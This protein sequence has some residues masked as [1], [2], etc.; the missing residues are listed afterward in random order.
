[1][2]RFVSSFRGFLAG[3]TLAREVGTG[4]LVSLIAGLQAPAL[5]AADSSAGPSAAGKVLLI[6]PNRA[7]CNIFLPSQHDRA[8]N[9]VHDLAVS[10]LLV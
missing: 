8:C 4:G 9:T 7:V 1:M 3:G 10:L 6:L 5:R 2:L